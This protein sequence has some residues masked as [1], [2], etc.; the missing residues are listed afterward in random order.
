MPAV[1]STPVPDGAPDDIPAADQ[2]SYVGRLEH[3]VQQA[4]VSQRELVVLLDNADALSH[5]MSEQLLQGLKRWKGQSSL[6]P[7]CLAVGG[8][9]DIT[10]REGQSHMHVFGHDSSTVM[11]LA[12]WSASHITELA[13]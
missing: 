10:E 12:T 11:R 6:L 13:R 3:A 4:R 7:A 1:E 8:V 5:D 2:G 9:Q